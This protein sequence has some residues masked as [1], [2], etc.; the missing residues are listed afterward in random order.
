MTTLRSSPAPLC[1]W[2]TWPPSSRRDGGSVVA[3]GTT[4]FLRAFAS[5]CT[6]TQKCFRNSS[7]KPGFDVNRDGERGDEVPRSS[8]GLYRVLVGGGSQPEGFFLDQDTA[9]P[10]ALQRLLERP[11]H[12]SALGAS[13][14]HVGSIARSGVGSEALDLILERVLPRY[15]RLQPIIILVGASDVLRWLEQGAPPCAR[16]RRARR[17]FSAAIPSGPFGWKP[18][19]A[20]ADGAAAE[21]PAALA[22][23]GR[24]VHERA[25]SWIGQ[26]RAMRARAKMIR[27]TMPDPAPMLDHFER[28]FRR[29]PPDG[30]GACRSRARRPPAVVRQGLLRRGGRAHVAR[31]RRDRRGDRKSP[32]TT[33]S[34]SSRAHGA[35]G[36]EP[37]GVAQ[38]ARRR[39]ARSDADPGAA[40]SDTT[41]TSST[42]RRQ[43]PG[44]SRPRSRPRSCAA[45]P[46][47]RRQRP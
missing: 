17:T 27:P 12:S 43:A 38:D 35:P 24:Q 39:A 15:P 32:P 46:L 8:E 9:W 29:A 45:A 44:P 23:A 3:I 14:V 2:S 7:G 40:A 11:E 25:G 22:P 28:H 26:A 13:K 16:L 18:R 1:H 21:G 37:R 31:R 33:R 19:R 36:R 4:S 42:P 30:D 47:G 6:S 10:G 41:T 34:T 5:A 20:R